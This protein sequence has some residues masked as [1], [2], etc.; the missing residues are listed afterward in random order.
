MYL[1]CLVA[2]REIEF[3]KKKTGEQKTE[4]ETETE[5]SH[6]ETEQLQD[7]VECFY[8]SNASNKYFI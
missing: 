6:E 2:C 7:K 5:A 4:E 3:L 8:L 1:I